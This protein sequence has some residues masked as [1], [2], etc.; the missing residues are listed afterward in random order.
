MY[1]VR[2][3]TFHYAGLHLSDMGFALPAFGNDLPLPAPQELD[4]EP[5]VF[6]RHQAQAQAGTAA[7][8]RRDAAA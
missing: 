8:A 6:S 7:Q 3:N 5:G 4:P 1:K 2:G